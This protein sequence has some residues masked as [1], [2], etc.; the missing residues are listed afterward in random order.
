MNIQ[1]LPTPK[2]IETILSTYISSFSAVAHEPVPTGGNHWSLYLTTP[3]YSI[4]LGMNPSYTVPATLNKGGSKGILI[5]SDI[6]NTDMI[7]ASATKI[8]HLDVRRDLKVSEF[9]DLLVS[10]G[11]Q[12]Y[13]SDSE[14]PS[15]RFWLHDQ[16]GLF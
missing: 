14:D 4:R 16:M 3:K 12:L 2:S 9:V 1:Y 13:E 10:E 5:I 6:P 7:S 8:V 15:C 11:R